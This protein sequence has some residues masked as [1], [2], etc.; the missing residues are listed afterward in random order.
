MRQRLMTYGLASLMLA[1]AWCSSL[2]QAEALLA[3]IKSTGMAATATA[4]PLDSL[5][6]A[7][8]PAAITELEDRI[9]FG[10][11]W[12]H[13]PQHATIRGNQA[14]IPNINGHYNASRRR[15]FYLAEGGF[16]KH[17]GCRMV[18]GAAIYNRDFNKTTFTK[19]VPLL[20]T[21][22]LGAEYAHQVASAAWAMKVIPCLSVGV[23]VN[24]H[25]QRVKLNGVEHFDSPLFTS[26][27]HHVTNKGY[28]Y[29]Q[30][31][32]C[33]VGLLW[34]V[35]H[36]VNLAGSY[37]PKAHM[38]SFDK[39]SGFLAQHGRI[40]IPEIITAGVAFRA[41]PTI[42][43]AFDYQHVGWE[44]IH[45]LHNPLV[46]PNPLSKD[47]LHELLGA[48]KGAGF[49]FRS[50]S[51]LRFGVNWDCCDWLTLRAGFRHVQTPV[52][53]SQT[54]ANLLTC[55]VVE[56]AATCGATW[57]MKCGNELSCFYAHL[58]EHSVRGKN[59]LPLSFGGGNVD[60]RQQKN[61]FG[62]TWGKKF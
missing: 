24:Y 7:Y 56:N 26:R 62:L 45:S 2:P 27:P 16:L 58:F 31:V 18:V 8:N 20:G 1:L 17:L 23:M 57:N 43:F 4:F 21:S 61:V 3:S 44:K 5:A 40:D 32:G 41:W 35:T 47:Y 54:A 25:L 39:Y 36:C 38:S 49:G 19:P 22:H 10:A 37:Q 55:D 33:G 48:K 34:N 13:S 51:Y 46:I 42:T 15:D 6:I 53:R 29:A 11:A 59:S 50:Q 52:R 14:P 9:D 28:N 60:L 12:D 30:G